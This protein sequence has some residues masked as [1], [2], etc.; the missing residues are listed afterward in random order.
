MAEAYKVNVL[1]PNKNVESL[2]KWKDDKLLVNET[3]VG[4]NVA[5]LNSGIFR[6]DLPENF[7]LNPNTFHSII[8]C[9]PDVVG[10]FKTLLK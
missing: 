1:F 2:E 9:I 7:C 6:C 3:Y 8:Q 10:I 4:G 5:Q